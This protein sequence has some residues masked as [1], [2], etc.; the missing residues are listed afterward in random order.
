[1]RVLGAGLITQG[2]LSDILYIDIVQGQVGC[3][4]LSDSPNSFPSRA[5]A[6]LFPFNTADSIP[7]NTI[8]L[9]LGSSYD[10]P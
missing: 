2:F 4:A 3:A 1:M 10:E 8:D 5:T 6:P 7:R 9:R